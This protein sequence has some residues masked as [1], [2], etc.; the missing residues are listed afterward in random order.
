[1]WWGS[2]VCAVVESLPGDAVVVAGFEGMGRRVGGATL[3]PTPERL[4]RLG[5]NDLVVT[6][7]E[8]IQ[9]VERGPVGRRWEQFVSRL[10]AADVAAVALRLNATDPLPSALVDAADKM[11][12]PII[13]FPASTELADVT[14]AVLDALL[15]AQG[16]RLERILDIHQQFTPIVL[17]GGGAPEIATTLHSLLK[18]PVAVVDPDGRLLAAVPSCV[19]DDP[20]SLDDPVARQ[21]ISAGDHHYGEILALAGG[22]DLDDDGRLALER[23]AS[24][25]AL[26]QAHATA[27]AAEQ[28][29]FAATSLEELISGNARDIADVVERANSFGWDLTRPRAVLLVSVDPWTERE[30]QSSSLGAIA[31]AA[32]ATLGSDTIVWARSTSVAALLAPESSAP[33]ERRRVADRLREELDEKVT[34][35][36][37]SI[38]VGR[39][40]DDPMQLPRS[41]VEASRA[42]D[43]GRWAKG[44]HVTEVFDE[45]GLERLLASTPAD[46]LADFVHQ[47]I[48]TLVDYDRVNDTDLVMTL[49]MWLET[50][51]TAEAARRMHVHYNT[52]K[53][54]LDRIQAVA[55]PVLSDSHRSLECAVAIY[56]FRHYD[57]PWIPA[58]M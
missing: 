16:R 17:A 18:C 23:A 3:A 42:V 51:N 49:G 12:L 36:T 9:A 54:R 47:A 11:S 57:G 50:R 58:T 28:E 30:H 41:Y 40:V 4:L 37:V 5:A 56:V 2:D 46:D 33:E 43:V 10:E 15:E 48:G 14:S 24:A 39:C 52:L 29:R 27:A 53:N 20:T 19:A 34:L 6:T 13:T 38:G 26:R 35:V 31:V 22:A 7:A 8:A 44:R 45:L 1:M 55:G 32:R 21:S 25:I